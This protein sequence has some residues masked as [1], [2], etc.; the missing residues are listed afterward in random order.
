MIQSQDPLSLYKND[1]IRQPFKLR[2][3]NMG[4]SFD[5]I[6]IIFNVRGCPL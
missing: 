4:G 6:A 1:L 3:P 2:N 5:D